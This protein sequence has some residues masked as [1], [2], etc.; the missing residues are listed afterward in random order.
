M[1]KRFVLSFGIVFAVLILAGCSNSDTKPYVPLTYVSF[2]NLTADGSDMPGGSSATTRLTLTFNKD[3]DGLSADDIILDAGST[4]AVKGALNRTG[5]GVY[6][7][8]VSGITESGRVTV[9]VSK[10]GY[11]IYNNGY[12]SVTVYR[13]PIT[14]LFTGLTADGSATVTTTKL[15]LTFD[16]DID[17]LSSWDITFDAGSTG[18][19]KGGLIKTGTGVYGLSLYGITASGTVTVSVSRS[20]YSIL[21]GPKQVQVYY[22][23]AGG[24]SI[25]VPFIGPTEKSILI[26]RTIYNNLSKSNYGSVTLTI[27]ENFNNYEWFTGGTKLATGKSVTL[28][29]SNQALVTGYNWIT[30]VVYTGT[31]AGAVPWSGEFVIVVNE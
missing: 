18:A 25:R 1:K 3:I 21:G 10:S 20:G 11:I 8:A 16:K 29:A 7:L 19:D 4:G 13:S 23:T 9:S 6:D 17:G 27:T 14:A 12:Q 15:T 24:N 28:Y 2:T 31:G 30:A 26:N 5:T 22:D